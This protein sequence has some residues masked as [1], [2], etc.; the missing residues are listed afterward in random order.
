MLVHCTSIV[1]AKAKV[2]FFSFRNIQYWKYMYMYRTFPAQ[3]VS[4]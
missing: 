2:S 4:L 3:S 1:H